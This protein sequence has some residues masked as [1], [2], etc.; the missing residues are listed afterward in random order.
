[1]HFAIRTS[2]DAS[3]GPIY[4]LVDCRTSS[5]TSCILL[6]SSSS[7]SAVVVLTRHRREATR[8]LNNTWVGSVN[9][10]RVLFDLQHPSPRASQR[11]GL[12]RRHASNLLPVC[13]VPSKRI[14]TLHTTH[15]TRWQQQ[16]QPYSLMVYT[17]PSFHSP[18]LPTPKYLVP[19]NHGLHN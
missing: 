12:P 9:S 4:F 18:P 3:R 7:S 5:H 10:T 15:C 19:P 17:P 16:I 1:M 2:N 14:Y 8:H 6:P 13:H 11:S